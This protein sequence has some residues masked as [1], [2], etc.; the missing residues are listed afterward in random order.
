ML[1][2]AIAVMH[3]VP[4]AQWIDLS[5]RDEA[6]GAARAVHRRSLE[7]NRSIPVD[8]MDRQHLPDRR[9]TPCCSAWAS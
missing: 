7:H 5:R 1:R 3:H 2:Y 6:R 9:E 4:P 8:A